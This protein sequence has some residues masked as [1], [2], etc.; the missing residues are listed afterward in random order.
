MAAI[1]IGIGANTAV[2][3]VEYALLLKSLPCARPDEIVFITEVQRGTN[4]PVN[5]RRRTRE[6][7]VRMAVGRNLSDVAVLVLRDALRMVLTGG[8]LGLQFPLVASR[9]LASMLYGIA[10]TN[11]LTLCSVTALFDAVTCLAAYL[12]ARRAAH[13]DPVLALRAD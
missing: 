4:N 7:G 10:S 3:S 6:I 8:V 2:F 11:A 1:G 13:V 5:V 12:P 9:W